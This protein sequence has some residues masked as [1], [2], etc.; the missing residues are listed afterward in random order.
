MMLSRVPVACLL[1]IT[2]R[3]ADAAAGV[4]SLRRRASHVG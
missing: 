1:V 4:G 3:N 2:T